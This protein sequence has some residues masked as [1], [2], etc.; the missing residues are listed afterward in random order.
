M[1]ETKFEKKESSEKYHHIHDPRIL[2]LIFGIDFFFFLG[3][4]HTTKRL[5]RFNYYFALKIF[6]LSFG[7][8]VYLIALINFYQNPAFKASTTLSIRL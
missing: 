3:Q 2:S 8:I 6:P 7:F 5:S 4:D 1:V